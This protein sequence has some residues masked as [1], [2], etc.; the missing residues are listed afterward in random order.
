L[1]AIEADSSYLSLRR[2]GL[3]VT[4]VSAFAD[5]K[6]ASDGSGIHEL[7]LERKHPSKMSDNI[8]KCPG[9]LKPILYEIHVSNR[10]LAFSDCSMPIDVVLRSREGKTFG[11]HTA[12]L[13]R[14]SGAFPRPDMITSTDPLETVD[15]DERSEVIKLILQFTHPDERPPETQDVPGDVML[16]FAEAVEKFIIF[17]AME[18]CNL[19]LA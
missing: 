5:R 1:F 3:D 6:R 16:E 10:C 18:V 8:L 13:A 19:R 11:A 9:N 15:L 12:F 2:I 4:R 14:Y 7:E 17:P